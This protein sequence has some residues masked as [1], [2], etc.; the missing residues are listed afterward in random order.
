MDP[1][2]PRACARSRMTTFPGKERRRSPGPAKRDPGDVAACGSRLWPETNGA[3]C[4]RS[5]HGARSGRSA[6]ASSLALLAP[7]SRPVSSVRATTARIRRRSRFAYTPHRLDPAPGSSCLR[8]AISIA[9]THPS[10]LSATH[11]ARGLHRGGLATPEKRWYRA[12]SDSTSSSSIK[13]LALGAGRQR[14]RGSRRR[15]YRYDEVGGEAS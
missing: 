11:T 5:V 3:I 14:R 10:G 7:I 8:A 4:V 2:S 13:W 6:I 15:R 9:L 12:V 1:G